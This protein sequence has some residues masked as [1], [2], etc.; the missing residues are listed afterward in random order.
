MRIIKGSAKD[1]KVMK[2]PTEDTCGLANVD[3]K[4]TY[5]IYDKGEMSDEIPGKGKALCDMA[6]YNFD[7]VD[8]PSHY[9]GRKSDTS[10]EILFANVI[11][12]EIEPGTE[13][14]VVPVEWIFRNDLPPGSSLLRRLESGE[15]LLEDVGLDHMPGEWDVLPE[16]VYDF[17][18]KFE[19][20]DRPLER[21]DLARYG[22]TDEDVGTLFEYTK[23]V[24]EF[25]TRHAKKIGLTHHD[26]KAE[27]IK[28][29]DNC[30]LLADVIGTPDENRFSF[31]KTQLSKEI[32]RQWYKQTEWYDEFNNWKKKVGK[33]H[34]IDVEEYPEPPT[35]PHVPKELIDVVSDM[36]RTVAGVW[37]GDLKKKELKGLVKE[38]N[39]VEGEL[40]A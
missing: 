37:V 31:K 25:I 18:T 23:R 17:T 3:A 38:I 1:T 24:N 19:R 22:L 29:S 15:L 12:E 8:V 21:K 30:I 16:P 4:D 34:W 33:K 11:K 2:E 39:R 26:G 35:P 5:S 20:F 10:F 14:F 6:C 27:Y 9:R 32:L 40:L 28:V 13:A 36:Y 7:H